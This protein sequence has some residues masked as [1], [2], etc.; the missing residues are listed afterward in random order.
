MSTKEMLQDQLALTR[1]VV[2]GTLADCTDQ[3]VAHI[4]DG[5]AHPI[6]ALYAHA[7]M[8]EDGIVNGVLR[9]QQPLMAADLTK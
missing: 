3:Q 5:I 6:G 9:K 4:P 2:D 7:T 1:M 8:S